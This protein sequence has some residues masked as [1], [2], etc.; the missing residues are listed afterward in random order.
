MVN[1]VAS[2][3][4][5]GGLVLGLMKYDDLCVP[6]TIAAQFSLTPPKMA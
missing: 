2:D 1:I 6:F 5:C 3:M 4:L